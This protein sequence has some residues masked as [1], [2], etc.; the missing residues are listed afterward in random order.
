MAQLQRLVDSGNTVIVVEHD[1]RVI[2]AC[3]WV[4]DMGPGGGGSGG[5][6]VAVGTPPQVAANPMSVTGRFLRGLQEKR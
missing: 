1:L 4:I 6:I 3:D 5:R 2:A